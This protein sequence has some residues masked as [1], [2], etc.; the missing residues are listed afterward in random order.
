MRHA[1][2]EF[3][4]VIGEG[5]VVLFPSDTVYGLACDPE[6]PEAIDR[7][8]ALKGRTADKSAAVMFFDLHAG[9]GAFRG[10]GQRT[11]AALHNLLPGRVTVLLPNPAHRFP[12]AC[13]ADPGTIGLRIIAVPQ[14]TGIRVP[15]LQSSA[16]PAGGDDARRV[17]EVHPSIRDGV[18]LVIDGGELPGIASTVVDLRSYEGSGAWT[19]ARAGAVDETRIASKLN[20]GWGFDP[21]TYAATVR[22]EIPGYDEFQELI[23]R[24]AATGWSGGRVLE[25]GTG[26]GETA[27]RLLDR[28][29]HAQL[30]SVDE[31]PEM[32]AAA[33]AA[34]PADR[35]QL[36]QSRL[37]DPLPEGP[38]E[39][40]VSALAIHHLD[41]HQKPELFLR[42]RAALRS[43][44]R[45]VLADVVVPGDPAGAR[46]PLTPGYDKPSSL[47][48]QLRWLRDAGFGPVEVVWRQHDLAIVAARAAG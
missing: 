4:R 25:L 44:G 15:V 26:T 45:F 48:D 38:F 33:A 32:L 37:Q 35:V 19:I 39:L 28:L 16:N 30:L 43:G 8:Y 13:R 27:Q 9:L 42:I 20:E 17:D 24:T 41:D 47:D 6:N 46:I 2:S 40:V 22:A 12:L 3:E 18:D 14:L 11:H 21:A 5:G 29:E 1:T 23:A 34:L 10:L 36:I 31:S 7:L